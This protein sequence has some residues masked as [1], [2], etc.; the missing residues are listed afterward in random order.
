MCAVTSSLLVSPFQT[1][2]G[3]VVELYQRPPFIPTSQQHEEMVTERELE[4]NDC[5]RAGGQRA[6]PIE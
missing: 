1:H 2:P 4:L 5:T 6:L 3:M